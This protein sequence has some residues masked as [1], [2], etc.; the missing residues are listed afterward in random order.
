MPT[1][2]VI[3]KDPN[4]IPSIEITKEKYWKIKVTGEILSVENQIKGQF[5]TWA[6]L[7]N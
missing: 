1:V 6:A 3:D 2:I 4:N 7:Y 5:L